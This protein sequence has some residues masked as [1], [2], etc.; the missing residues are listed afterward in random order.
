MLK[1]RWRSTEK[2]SYYKC[3]DK[4]RTETGGGVKVQFRQL[5]RDFRFGVSC[6]RAG[7]GEPLL[8]DLKDSGF[9]FITKAYYGMISSRPTITT[10]SRELTHIFG[11]DKMAD[12][13]FKLEGHFACYFLDAYCR[14]ICAPLQQT[15]L[16][17]RLTSIPGLC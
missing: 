11:V 3:C 10:T 17:L 9:N 12:M 16:R 4:R 7:D 13:G 15:S 6:R 5:D 8:Q 1:R 2:L 14:S